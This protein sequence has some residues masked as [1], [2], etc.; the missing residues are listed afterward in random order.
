MRRPGRRPSEA[1]LGDGGIDDALFPE[2]VQEAPRDLEG[3]T[4]GSDVL[5][6]EEDRVIGDHLLEETLADGLEESHGLT[7]LGLRYVLRLNRG[8][9]RVRLALRRHVAAP[10][11]WPKERWTV[12]RCLRRCR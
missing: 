12:S 6:D 10:A 5:P 8:H 3:A 4:V 11:S 7:A 2:I 1:A 9:D